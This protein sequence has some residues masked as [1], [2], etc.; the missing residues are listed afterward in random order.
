MVV[1]NALLVKKILFPIIP[2]I[3]IGIGL[4]IFHNAWLAI[5]G[6]HAGM[7]AVLSLL[8]TGITLKRAFQGDRYW[9]TFISA[10]AGAGGGI[11]L[12]ILWP[13]L[14]VPDD[15]NL[16]IRSIGLNEGAWPVFLAYFIL[17]NPLIEEYYWRGYLAGDNKGITVNDL[18][19]SGYHLI[20]L[21]G[22]MEAIWLITVFFSLTIGAWF[23]RQMNR[24]NGG[25]LASTVSHITADITVILTIYYISIK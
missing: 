10:L 17:I 2:Y 24:L 12:Y 4:L 3:T 5:L 25:L 21:A 1:M 9:V 11:L 19:F 8:K 7:V 20:V 15:I 6:Y 16:Y 22:Q 23:W 18:L 14:S 13:L